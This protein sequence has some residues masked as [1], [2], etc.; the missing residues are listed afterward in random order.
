[1]PKGCVIIVIIHKEGSNKRLIANT[2]KEWLTPEECA[3]VATKLQNGK[4]SVVLKKLV[5]E[6]LISDFNYL[7]SFR[8]QELIVL[9]AHNFNV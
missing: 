7:Y 8:V 1:M 2:Q 4:N 3:T 6:T 5:K 9:F